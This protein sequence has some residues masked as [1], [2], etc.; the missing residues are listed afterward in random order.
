M[1]KIP[2]NFTQNLIFIIIISGFLILS[3]IE[4]LQ[5][6]TRNS[7]NL[8]KSELSDCDKKR[9]PIPLRNEKQNVEK[10][11]GQN[12]IFDLIKLPVPTSDSLK[13]FLNVTVDKPIQNRE[14]DR[15]IKCIEKTWYPN[16]KV[17][18]HDVPKRLIEHLT[19]NPITAPQKLLD[20]FKNIKPWRILNSNLIPNPEKA[21]LPFIHIP[22]TAGSEVK[23]QIDLLANNK[24]WKYRSSLFPR[25]LFDAHQFNQIPNL[26][27]DSKLLIN[28]S[29]YKTVFHTSAK[30]LHHIHVKSQ[31]SP[32]CRFGGGHGGTHCGYSEIN[33]CLVD[34]YAN[35]LHDYD[36][37]VFLYENF[38]RYKLRK[39]EKILENPKK[40]WDS[41]VYEKMIKILGFSTS[42]IHRFSL[43]SS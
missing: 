7:I 33:E 43:Q 41:E 17:K 1:T 15:E 10:N 24:K 31:M 36:E 16:E 13:D 14:N 35:L 28:G 32:G 25:S 26:I 27:D 20:M 42:E 5:S 38:F 11:S 2:N 22:K 8:F 37:S 9:Y 34:G 6:H 19:A 12:E 3:A 21:I 4:Y 18:Y 39:R 29:V 40:F 30:E 23:V